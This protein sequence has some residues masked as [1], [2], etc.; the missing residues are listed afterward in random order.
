MKKLSSF[1]FL[2]S[3]AALSASAQK[4]TTAKPRPAEWADRP[5]VHPV[6]PEFAK[7]P[8]IMLLNEFSLDYRVEGKSFNMYSTEHRL[9]K[10]LDDRGIE[11]YN[12]L[13]IP[14]YSG[15]RVPSIKARTILPNG[16]VKEIAQ[17]MI[18]VTKNP[19]GYWSIIIAMEGVEKYSEIE[20]IIKEIHNADYFGSYTFQYDIPVLETHF[21][22]SESVV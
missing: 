21:H 17:D 12:T 5:V 16:K 4:Y 9:I 2:C 20:Y 22:R 15:T 19:H 1:I 10:V 8:A 11:T 14:V 13:D 18:L 6:P 7:E 3:V